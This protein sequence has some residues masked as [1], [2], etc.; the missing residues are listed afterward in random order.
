MNFFAHQDQAR[1]QTRRMLAMFVL[2]VVAI[3]VAI[4]LVV[5]IGIGHGRASAGGIAVVSALVLGVIAM[6]ST[7]RIATLRGGGAAVAA[8]LGARE[9]PNDTGEFAYRRLRNVVEEIAI[10][11]GVPVPQVFVLEGEAGIN[12]F[13]AGY[14]PADAAI[15]VTRGALDK[16]TREELQGVIGHEFSHVLN[17]DMRLNI[18]LVGV[19]FGILVVSV[20]GRKIAEGVGRGGRDSSGAVVFGLALAAAGYIGV[21]FGRIIKA[22]ISRQREFLADASAVQFTRQTE[23]IAGAL[24][25]IGA[26]A[27]GSRLDSGDKEEVAHMLFGDGVGY[28][29]LFA[30]HPPLEQ[31]IRRLEP[32]FR[33]DELRAI[34][35]AWSHPTL[36]DDVDA[37][38]VSIAGFAPVEGGAAKAA[39]ARGATLPSAQARLHIAPG[40][41][42]RQVGNPGSDDR[43]AARTLSMEIPARLREAA[44]QGE[45]AMPLLFALVLNDDA[46]LRARQLGLV[47]R[48]FD[49]GTG[50]LARE[51][52][53]A[54]AGLHP[55]Q[56]LPLAALAFPALR[57]RPRAQ[58]EAFIA[59]LDELV[60]ADGQVT[61]DEYCLARLVGLQVGDA[62]DP[63]T[64]RILGRL[65]LGD[66]AAE[67]KDVLAIVARH[68]HDDAVAA[69]RAYALGLADVLP[70]ATIAY[71]PPSAWMAALDRALPRL[72]R[73][74]AAGKELVV[75]GLTR[76]ISADGTVSVAEAELLR[77]ICAALHCPLPPL[78][79]AT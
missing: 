2:A 69:Q 11:A 61:L 57:R 36:V 46:D 39:T 54:L 68:G 74:G 75:G 18:R 64:T 52:G 38:G 78:L 66:V 67:L 73:L 65:K 59:L 63:A 5:V 40:K 3:V 37:P 34:A 9:V 50:A 26:L 6:G 49:S 33:S 47:A 60:E 71:A 23:G 14:A 1:R 77:T 25:K 15:T 45:Q 24:K 13:A 20:I 53:D 30:T 19:V 51:L 7:Y 79:Q 16:L 76:A 41:V 42:V 8:Q 70:A 31:R 48:R 17:G 62:L 35:A 22:S 43:A 32:S 29:A 4:D 58:L 21:V 44:V 55:M 27:E 12:A 56:R 10:A 72:D 28:S